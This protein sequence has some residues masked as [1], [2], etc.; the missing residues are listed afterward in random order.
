MDCVCVCVKYIVCIIKLLFYIS[1]MLMKM[2]RMD[3]LHIAV[4]LTKLL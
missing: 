2:L 1:N 3:D 4:I